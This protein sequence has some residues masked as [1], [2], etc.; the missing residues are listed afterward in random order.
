MDGERV[1]IN[2]NKIK[3]YVYVLNLIEYFDKIQKY[4]RV[5]AVIYFRKY[6]T[7]S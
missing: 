3:K 2:E 4:S 5:F 7:A 1:F 6:T